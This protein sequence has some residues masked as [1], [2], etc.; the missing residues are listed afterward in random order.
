[1]FG[2]FWHQFFSSCHRKNYI[3]IDISPL[4][5]AI[6]SIVVCLVVENVRMMFTVRCGDNDDVHDTITY[7]LGFTQCNVT[8]KI[9][10][11]WSGETSQ[12][13]QHGSMCG[14]VCWDPVEPGAFHLFVRVIVSH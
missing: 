11:N 1:M 4:S 6:T 10:R 12:S 8:I 7:H 3:D 2:S 13:H 5:T 9:L 14:D